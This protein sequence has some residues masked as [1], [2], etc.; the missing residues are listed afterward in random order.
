MLCVQKV[1]CFAFNASRSIASRSGFNALRSKGSMLRVQLLR[2]QGSMLCVQGSMLCVQQLRVQGSMQHVQ[3]LIVK[4]KKNVW[5]EVYVFEII[6]C[7]LSFNVRF[8]Q[9]AIT[10]FILP[11]RTK[12][13]F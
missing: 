13:H 4:S 3:N 10:N 5:I 9:F 12:Q 11:Y 1:Q 2:V 6:C 8:V 7:T